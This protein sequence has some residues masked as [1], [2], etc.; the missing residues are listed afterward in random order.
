MRNKILLVLLMLACLVS[1]GFQAR[2][3][4]KKTNEPALDET[5]KWLKEKIGTEAHHKRE[6]YGTDTYKVDSITFE[7]CSVSY[8]SVYESS[9]PADPRVH[10]Q[11]YNTKADLSA[12]DPGS[13]KVDKAGARVGKY[14]VIADTFNNE[15]KFQHRYESTKAGVK[16]VRD[17]VTS[18]VS[19]IFSDEDLANRV[20]K[21]LTHAV[22]SCRQKKQPF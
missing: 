4:Q 16:E 19:F 8:R 3:A 7:G 15:P 21:A 1:F 11:A 14:S 22:Q 13:V 20:A 10:R 6:G 18:Q 5:L 12:L 17:D 2:P 9:Y